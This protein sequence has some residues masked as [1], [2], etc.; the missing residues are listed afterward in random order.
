MREEQSVGWSYPFSGSRSVSM[1]ASLCAAVLLV[2]VAMSD[3]IGHL[4]LMPVCVLVII[5]RAVKEDRTQ[6]QPQVSS[7]L[8]K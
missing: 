7:Q 3:R 1:V 2:I 8:I 5:Q 4:L 6:Q